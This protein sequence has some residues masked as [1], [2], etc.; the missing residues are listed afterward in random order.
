MEEGGG[1]KG[2][3]DCLIYYS[4]WGVDFHAFLIVVLDSACF[5]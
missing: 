3:Q 2:R 4:T 5:L 1:W